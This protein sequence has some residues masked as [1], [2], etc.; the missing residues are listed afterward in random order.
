MKDDF[1]VITRRFPE[2]DDIRIY[3]IYDVHKGAKEHLQKAFTEFI[4]SI[5]RDPNAYVILG[6]DLIN[7]ALKNSLSNVYEETMRPRE[8]KRVMT[9]LLRPLAEADRVIACVP[10]NHERRSMKEADDDPTYD[11][12][13]KL[14]IEDLYRPNMAFIKLQ[15]GKQNGDGKKNP[16]YRILAHHGSGG[17]ALTG[18]QV[19]RSER[20]A[21]TV[22]GIDLFMVGHSHKPYV[23]AP[24]KIVFDP[25]WDRVSVKP[26]R[27]CSFASWLAYGGYA[28]TKML[29]PTATADDVPQWATIYGKRKKIEVTM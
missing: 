14:D 9:E 29:P 6:G 26:Y 25:Y 15:F 27:V 17:G 12:C 2:R 21:A 4:V 5:L 24:S 23:T 13:A 1:D 28:A 19:N 7:N 22:D 8:Q 10:G 11:I 18:G 20:F 3:G 16:T